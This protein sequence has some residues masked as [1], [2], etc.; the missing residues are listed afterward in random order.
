M[1]S[2]TVIVICL[3][4]VLSICKAEKNIPDGT[5]L[6]DLYGC[7]AL[8]AGPDDIDAYTDQDYVYIDFHQNFGNVS[9]SLYNEMGI[10]VYSDVVNTAVQQTVIIPIMGSTGGTYTL[11]LENAT[12]YAEGAFNKTP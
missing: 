9:I 2:K 12:G 11:V 3:M 5:E 10:M 7:L 4:L 8:N 6:I 1:K